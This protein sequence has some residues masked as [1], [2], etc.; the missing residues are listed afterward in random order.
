[1]SFE[2]WVSETQFLFTKPFKGEIF[3]A[4]ETLEGKQVVLVLTREIKSSG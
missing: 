2:S 1:M 3:H 4:H